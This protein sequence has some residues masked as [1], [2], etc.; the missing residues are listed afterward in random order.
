MP[1]HWRSPTRHT[2]VFIVLLSLC[3][4]KTLYEGLFVESKAKFFDSRYFVVAGKCWLHGESPYDFNVYKSVWTRTCWGQPDAPFFYPPT[5]LIFFLPLGLFDWPAAAYVFQGMNV[6]AYALMIAGLWLLTKPVHGFRAVWFLLAAS[7]G[8]IQAILLMGQTS[9]MVACGFTWLVIAIER[10]SISLA[11]LAILVLSIKPHLSGPVILAMVLAN[12]WLWKPLILSALVAAA[13]TGLAILVQPTLISDVLSVPAE[14]AKHPSNR[15]SKRIGFGSLNASLGISNNL[16][17]NI[18]IIIYAGALFLV[19]VSRKRSESPTAR[20]SQDNYLTTSLVMPGLLMAIQEYDIVVYTPLIILL[21]RRPAS[22]WWVFLPLSACFW[23]PHVLEKIIT[24]A[25]F[26]RSTLPTL[27]SAIWVLM[28][29][30]VFVVCLWP[31]HSRSSLQTKL[32]DH[33][34]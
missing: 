22:T 16:S 23:R 15:I 31:R 7:F 34:A 26:P 2:L 9:I 13:I 21:G 3:I 6:L 28:F 25:G 5:A 29:I 11:T 17:R 20:D 32:Q 19:G 14:Y 12:R 18:S 27:L 8:S 1:I 10:K 30:S 24:S 4:G 33:Q